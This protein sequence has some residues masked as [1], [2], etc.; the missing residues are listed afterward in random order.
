MFH[1]ALL[2]LGVSGNDLSSVTSLTIVATGTPKFRLQFRR[3]VDVIFQRI[4]QNGCLQQGQNRSFVT[5]PRQELG[6]TNQMVDVRCLLG[7]PCA[8]AGNVFP[9]ANAAP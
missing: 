5:D 2:A 1:L 4:V 3:V 6:N 7:T 8:S 9:A